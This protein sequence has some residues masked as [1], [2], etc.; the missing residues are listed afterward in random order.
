MPVFVERKYTGEVISGVLKT[1][2]LEK[3]GQFC[4]YFFGIF[5][6]LEHQFLFLALPE[7]HLKVLFLVR[8]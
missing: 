4:K 8:Q 6:I 1:C 2:K 5:E 7:K 3:N